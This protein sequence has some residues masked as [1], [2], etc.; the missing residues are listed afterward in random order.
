MRRYDYQGGKKN[1]NVSSL[2]Q[3]W[4][5]TNPD[6]C[7]TPSKV[8]CPRARHPH[9]WFTYSNLYPMATRPSR[10]DRRIR[11]RPS[12][13]MADRKAKSTW[14]CFIECPPA[15]LP[16]RWS[17][18]GMHGKLASHLYFLPANFSAVWTSLA[19]ISAAQRAAPTG[20]IRGISKF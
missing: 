3:F 9:G 12:P 20:W 6:T 4:D 18:L 5:I 8:K 17:W 7:P 15:C 1:S 14:H 19:S 13:L 11:A 2:L 10:D 16:A